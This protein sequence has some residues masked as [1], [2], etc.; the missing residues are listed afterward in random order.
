MR[1]S[2]TL[3]ASLAG[4]L[5]LAA[6][7]PALAGSVTQTNLVSD[8]SIP[9]AHVD[10]N[11]VNPWGVSY[12]P[13]GAFWVSDNATSLST[14]YV[15]DGTP[16][17]LI[18]TIPGGAAAA[19]P[20][21]P[22]GQVFNATTG[23]TVSEAGKTGPSVFIF[24]TEQGTISGWAP[25]VDGVNAIN[26]VDNSAQ[27]AVYK[28]LAI[29]TFGAQTYL[30]ATNFAAGTVEVYDSGWHLVRSFRDRTIPM[31]YGPFNVAVLDG[32]ILV[33]YAKHEK[34]SIDNANGPGLGYVEQ[35]GIDGHVVR[36]IAAHGPLNAPWGLAIAPATF[37][38][39][40][41]DLLVG[42]FGDGQVNVYGGPGLKH[43]GVLRTASGA[44]LAIEG[45]WAL[46]PGNGGSGGNAGTL[47][48][49]AGPADES[50]GLF[51]ALDWAE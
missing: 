48:F 4:A 16:Q 39:F 37:G 31:S 30:L 27:G 32:R 5:L 19:G 12:S 51:G 25:S 20:G 11:L 18:V 22:T 34:G 9:A 24:A 2:A 6:P 49:T 1:F 43:R 26:G 21:S 3:H 42:N 36:V 47:Y 10:P 44:P 13:T 50:E 17:S 15:T 38:R 28:G 8:G 23:F 40:A 46:I 33:T 45:L 29:G 7:L 14:L 35:V 41:G